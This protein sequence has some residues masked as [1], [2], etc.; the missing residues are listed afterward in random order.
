ML[1]RNGY[2]TTTIL[3]Q[4]GKPSSRTMTDAIPCQVLRAGLA[5]ASTGHS[6]KAASPPPAWHRHAVAHRLDE[7]LQPQSICICCRSVD[8]ASCSCSSPVMAGSTNLKL[9]PPRYTVVSLLTSSEAASTNATDPDTHRRKG[10][11]RWVQIRRTIL[12]FSSS[13]LSRSTGSFFV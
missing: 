11:C 13:T 1:W 10:C 7:Q 5:G 8:G 4:A 2:D 9:Y 12:L 6:V 3:G